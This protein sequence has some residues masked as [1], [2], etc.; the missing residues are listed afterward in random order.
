[1]FSISSS[2]SGVRDDFILEKLLLSTKKSAPT[3]LNTLVPGA[4]QQG[5]WFPKATKLGKSA[6]ARTTPRYSS[7]SL[8]PRRA[9]PPSEVAQALANEPSLL[10]HPTQTV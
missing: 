9:T 1:M 8:G 3:P 6:F 2:L 7:L 5:V 4:T 10:S